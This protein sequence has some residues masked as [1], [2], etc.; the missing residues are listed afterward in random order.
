LWTR[1]LVTGG[2]IV[3]GDVEAIVDA[4]LDGVLADSGS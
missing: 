1:L 3:E 2:V 4:V